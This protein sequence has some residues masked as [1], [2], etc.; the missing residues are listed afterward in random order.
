MFIYKIVHLSSNKMYVGKTTK[1]LNQRLQRHAY[2]ARYEKRPTYFH[3][4]LLKY[5]IDEFRIYLLEEIQPTVDI[6]ERERFWIAT[7]QP[8]YNL[9][10]GGTGGDTSQSPNFRK[11]MQQTSIRMRG[12]TY[13]LGKRNP[14]TETRRENIRQSRLGK[15]HP[16]R[17]GR[18][19]NGDS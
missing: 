11:A 10:E 12:N 1:T 2:D 3:S 16:H 5:G 9:T 4:A 15:P 13:M 6:N 7:I 17:G 8:E 19:S 14:M 18:R